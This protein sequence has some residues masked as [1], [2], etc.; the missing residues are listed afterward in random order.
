MTR[1]R[2]KENIYKIKNRAINLNVFASTYRD[3]DR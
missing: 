1:K 3:I 2:K